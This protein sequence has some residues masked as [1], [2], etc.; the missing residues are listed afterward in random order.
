L[1]F[2]VWLPTTAPP[3]VPAMVAAVFPRPLPI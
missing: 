2:S 1:F 3:I